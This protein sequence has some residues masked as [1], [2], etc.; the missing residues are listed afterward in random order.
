MFLCHYVE[1][2]V[3]IQPITVIIMFITTVQMVALRV[4]ILIKNK[5]I[6]SIREVDTTILNSGS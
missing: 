4:A 2:Y 3:Y 1:I 5:Q 6:T